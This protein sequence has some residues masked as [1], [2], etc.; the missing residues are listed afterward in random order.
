MAL[1]KYFCTILVRILEEGDPKQGKTQRK[2]INNE[3]H[4]AYALQ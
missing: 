2:A 1:Y 4:Q 3:R